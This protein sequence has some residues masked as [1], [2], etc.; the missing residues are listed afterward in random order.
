MIIMVCDGEDPTSP[1]LQSPDSP[2][3]PVT[4]RMRDNSV[5]SIDKDDEDHM[6]MRKVQS[7]NTVK[8]S[9]AVTCI[10][11]SPFSCPVRKF[12]MN[13]VSFKRSPVL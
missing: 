13:G 2:N 4:P 6:I 12:H 10:K 7:S 3:A 9:L 5:S 11:R 8:H 1:D